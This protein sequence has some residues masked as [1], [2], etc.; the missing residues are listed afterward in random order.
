MLHLAQQTIRDWQAADEIASSA[1]R[2]LKDAWAA[3]A[4]NRRP[5]PSKELMDEVSNAR[6][7]AN[8]LLNEAM[9]LMAEAAL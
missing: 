5:P 1:E 3:F 8:S 6:S 2:R 7:L 9:R 4:A